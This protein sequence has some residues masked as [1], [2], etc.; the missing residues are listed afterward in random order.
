LLLL[1]NESNDPPPKS[2]VQRPPILV[3]YLDSN[4]TDL[5]KGGLSSKAVIPTLRVVSSNMLATIFPEKAKPCN[6][7]SFSINPE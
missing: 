4:K 5:I 2:W 3:F 7:P 1:K 6:V